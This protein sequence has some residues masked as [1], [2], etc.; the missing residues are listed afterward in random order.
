LIMMVCRSENPFSK[1]FGWMS[2]VFRVGTSQN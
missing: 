1:A 2:G